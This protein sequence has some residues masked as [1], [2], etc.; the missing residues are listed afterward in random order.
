MLAMLEAFDPAAAY[1]WLATDGLILTEENIR[2]VDPADARRWQEAGGAYQAVFEHA[3]QLLDAAAEEDAWFDA[4][5]EASGIALDELG[6]CIDDGAMKA[7]AHLVDR[8]AA[9]RAADELCAGM[10]FAAFTE[11]DALAEGE[12]GQAALEA[13]R[14]LAAARFD[15]TVVDVL[16]RVVAA[17]GGLPEGDMVVHEQAPDRRQRLTVWTV[18]RA[19]LRATLGD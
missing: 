9:H 10:D 18:L 15:A 11:L 17:A 14:R 8:I 2:L 6:A 7:W 12:T 19:G 16:D 4:R 3:D 13:T 1:A 5:T